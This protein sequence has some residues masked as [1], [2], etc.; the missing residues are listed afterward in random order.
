MLR[1]SPFL[2]PLFEGFVAAE[3]AKLQA[4]AGRRREL[5]YFRD[6]QGLEVDFLV[7]QG[8]ARLLL[9][10]A[11]ASATLRAQDAEPLVR[12]RRGIRRYET[13]AVVVHR[14]VPNAPSLTALRPAVSAV[15]VD[16]LE[17]LLGSGRRGRR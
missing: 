10:E 7:P 16:Q 9:L 14:P 1:R 12:L 17:G 3:L 13:T 8:P 4:G 11:K 15:T 2:G 6:Q 5:Y